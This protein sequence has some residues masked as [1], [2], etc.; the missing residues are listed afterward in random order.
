[1]FIVVRGA[2]FIIDVAVEVVVELRRRLQLLPRSSL[3]FQ[4]EEMRVGVGVHGCDTLVEIARSQHANNPA[5]HS[6]TVSQFE[7]SAIQQ[8]SNPA[9]R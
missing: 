3:R 6:P 2:P 4:V 1:M 9:V 8:S 5:V 7:S